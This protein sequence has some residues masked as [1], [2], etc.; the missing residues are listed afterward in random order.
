VSDDPPAQ[1][2]RSHKKAETRRAIEQAAVQIAAEHG[3]AATT[4]AAI[5][6]QANVSLRTLFN[7]FPQRDQA[8]CGPTIELT[9]PAQVRRQLTEAPSVLDGVLDAF[10]ACAPALDGPSGA[11]RRTLIQSIPELLHLHSSAIDRFER[12]LTAL[13]EEE[14]RA[15]PERRRLG[16]AVSPAEEARLIVTVIGGV[17]RFGMHSWLSEPSGTAAPRRAAIARVTSQLARILQVG[18]R[19]VDAP[20]DA[21]TPGH[22]PDSTETRQ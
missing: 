4:A 11:Q 22:D 15:R 21:G 13:V 18:E 17:M 7:Y 3:Y 2:L 10:D 12:E 19:G 16:D 20:P 1:G 6:E 14:F 9:D 8:I 5:A